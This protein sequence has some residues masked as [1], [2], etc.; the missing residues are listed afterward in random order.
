MWVRF[1]SG[2]FYQTTT[3]RVRR[4]TDANLCSSA[5]VD[6]NYTFALGWRYS[7]T[8]IDNVRSRSITTVVLFN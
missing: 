3:L 6:A 4:S 7:P 1:E 5:T 8:V 2:D